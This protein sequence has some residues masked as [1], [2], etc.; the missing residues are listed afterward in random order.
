MSPLP[1]P[2][3][4]WL[5]LGY[6]GGFVLGLWLTWHGIVEWLGS[7]AGKVFLGL[8]IL[9]VLYSIRGWFESDLQHR[10]RGE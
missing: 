7:G 10:S 6:V 1:S 9:L 3:R 2:W 4:P 5:Q 8:L